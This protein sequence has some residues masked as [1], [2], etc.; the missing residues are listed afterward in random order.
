MNINVSFDPV[1]LI[2]NAA[3]GMLACFLGNFIAAVAVALMT[4]S[5]DGQSLYAFAGLLMLAGS[6]VVVKVIVAFII[7]AVAMATTSTARAATLW[8]LGT[9]AVLGLVFTLIMGAGA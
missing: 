2:G 9:S 5:L 4:P 3:L 1:R 8:T 6:M 7:A